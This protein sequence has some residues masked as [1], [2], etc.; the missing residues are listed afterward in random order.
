[1]CGGRS[2]VEW[3]EE[4]G[5]G[6]SG[7]GGGEVGELPAADMGKAGGVGADVSVEPPK[8]DFHARA[9]AP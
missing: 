3:N 2:E 4:S 1:V 9:G 5:A 8:L 7:K 6:D